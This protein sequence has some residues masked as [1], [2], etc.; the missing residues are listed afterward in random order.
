MSKTAIHLAVLLA[1]TGLA[2]QASAQEIERG[3]LKSLD[4]EK[5]VLIV[6]ANGKDRELTLTDETRVLDARGN[7]LAE[8]LADFKAGAEMQFRAATRDGREVAL[9]LRLV[10]NEQRPAGS[11]PAD[12]RLKRGK[13]VM[14]DAEKNLVTLN[15]DG[16]DLQLALMDRTQVQGPRGKTPVDRLRAFKAD[17][18]FEFLAETREGK[19]VLASIRVAPGQRTSPDHASFKPLTEMG[20]SQYLGFAGGLYPDGKNQR[21]ADHEAA[22]RKLAEHIR[23]LGSDGQPDDGGK[24]V[25][26]SLGMS[27]AS[28]VSE[29]FQSQLRMAR[30]LNPKF[31][32][33]NGA[34]GGMVAEVIMNPDDGGRGQQYWNVVD[35]RLQQNGVTRQQVQAVWIKQAD[36]APAQGFPEYPQKLQRELKRIVQLVA[37]RFPNARLC[38]LSSRTYGGFATTLLNPE[39]VAYESGFAA[40]WLI[41]EQIKG[42]AE[43]NYDPARGPVKAPWLSWGPY[44]WANGETKRGDGFSYEPADFANDGTHHASSGIR[45]TGELLLEFFRS[46]ATTKPWVMEH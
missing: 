20:T 14:I 10:R 9:G 2:G 21:P 39:P 41:E 28:Q 23:P 45:K 35:Q 17:T 8:K 26:L 1:L 5:R 22:G 6:T 3:K 11:P 13:V 43:L 44:L 25:L 4:L 42:D 38:Y 37:E 32:F 33:V 24:I 18:L 12:S 19:P 27:N 34:Q 31:Q 16:Q 30:G 15:V 46:D 36:A 7:T 40:K 29:G